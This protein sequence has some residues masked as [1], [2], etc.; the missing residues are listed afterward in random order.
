MIDQMRLPVTDYDKEVA[1]FLAEY[2]QRGIHPVDRSTSV[3]GQVRIDKKERPDDWDPEA[4]IGDL[5]EQF[6]QAAEQSKISLGS[7]FEGYLRKCLET[8]EWRKQELK[9]EHNFAVIDR[10]T[11]GNATDLANRAIAAIKKY[12]D[13]P[14]KDRLVRV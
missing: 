13:L 14:D 7:T 12:L 4:F 9:R 1:T 6:L 2:N 8:L 11:L 3:T 10:D 5:Y